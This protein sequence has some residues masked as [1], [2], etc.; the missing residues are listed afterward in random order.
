MIDDLQTILQYH[1]SKK[2]NAELKKQIR[3]APLHE[4][5]H[6]RDENEQST[7]QKNL[8]PDMSQE[9]VPFSAAL[10]EI[11]EVFFDKIIVDFKLHRIEILIL[12]YIYRRVWNYPN[13]HRSHGISPMMSHTEMAKNLS[14]AIEEVYSGLRKLE[15]Y[16][17]IKTIRAGQYFSRRYF[18][19]ELDQSFGQSYDDFEI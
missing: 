5:N 17:L 16:G 2:R 13:L 4:H 8:D 3:D 15:E 14:L 19:L 10:L 18:T 11:P 12:M 7:L 1:R 6:F 9:H